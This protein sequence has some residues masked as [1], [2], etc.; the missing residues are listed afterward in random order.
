MRS[1]AACSAGASAARRKEAPAFFRSLRWREQRSD[2]RVEPVVLVR[3]DGRSPWNA[4]PNVAPGLM[5]P[6]GGTAEGAGHRLNQQASRVE[7]RFAV[8]YLPGAIDLANFR[9]HAWKQ[10][11]RI[12]DVVLEYEG[13]TSIFHEQVSA[14]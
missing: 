10:S 13:Q 6:K 1:R 2:A 5:Q 4:E 3:I 14:R 9:A 11:L 12:Q 7:V 8:D